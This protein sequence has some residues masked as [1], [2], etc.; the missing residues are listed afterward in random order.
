[1]EKSNTNAGVQRQSSQIQ[2]C[3]RDGQVIYLKQYVVDDWGGDDVVIRRRAARERELIEQIASSSSFGRRLGVVR[4]A[5]TDPA[6]AVIATHEV[7]GNS[8]EQWIHSRDYRHD[9]LMPWFL[10]GRWLSCFQELPIS[11]SANEVFAAQDQGTIVQYCEQRLDSMRDFGATWPG[12]K[13]KSRL[14]ETL[15]HSDL[16]SGRRVWVH[17]DYAP[18]NLMW[19]N[20]TLTPIDFAMARTGHQLDDASY[21]IHRLEMARVYRPWLKIPVSAFRQ[22]ILRGLGNERADQTSAYQS[23]ATK[24]LICRLHT[25]LRRPAKNH[26]QAIHDRWVRMVLRRKLNKIAYSSSGNQQLK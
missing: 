19:G 12:A 24:H 25:Y 21:L 4:I 7:P 15:A 3:T 20:G 9:E 14:L 16:E 1:M 11:D 17:A 13:T 6:N 8:L 2:K 26:V 23:L 18:G 5:D 10:A 22:A